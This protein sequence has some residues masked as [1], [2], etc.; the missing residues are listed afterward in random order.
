MSGWTTS[1]RWAGVKRN[2]IMGL[3]R[4][5]ARNVDRANGK[6]AT[7]SNTLINSK[8]THLNEAWVND[9]EG[10]LVPMTDVSQAIAFLNK[11]LVEVQPVR[12]SRDGTMKKMRSARMRT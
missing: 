1:Y 12:K 5:D 11:K 9:G 8:Y 6:E 10:K 3:L 4:H 2:E 7:H